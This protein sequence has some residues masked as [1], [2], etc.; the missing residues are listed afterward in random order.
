MLHWVTQVA[1]FENVTAAPAGS[2]STM[3][4]KFA[5]CITVAQP[6]IANEPIATSANFL[7]M[8]INDPPFGEREGYKALWAGQV[9]RI[10]FAGTISR[11][12]TKKTGAEAL[13]LP[14]R[15]CH[16][17]GA[18]FRRRGT[19]SALLSTPA[20]ADGDPPRPEALRD[21]SSWSAS[22]PAIISPARPSVRLR[23]AASSRSQISGFSF[24]YCFEFS[25]PWPMRMLS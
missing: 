5:P 13:M 23:I 22:G 21:Q 14:R 24:R 15:P 9:S 12:Q 10:T 25:R 19:G 3:N 16:S 20:E 8:I 7:I 2:D 1:P 18:A 17:E 4:F 11:D 6:D